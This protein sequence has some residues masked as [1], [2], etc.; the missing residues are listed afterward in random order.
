MIERDVII[1]RD[2][3]ERLL[4]AVIFVRQLAVFELDSLAFGE[5][6]NL[7]VLSAGASSVAAPAP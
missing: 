2:I 6:R 1:E 4:F 5:E 3:E 7:T